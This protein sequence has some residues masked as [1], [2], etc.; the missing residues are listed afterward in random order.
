[1]EGQ[2]T[3]GMP[4]LVFLTQLPLRETKQLIAVKRFRVLLNL[5]ILNLG[6]KGFS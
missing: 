1:M 5:A 6:L 3:P 2:V 4:D